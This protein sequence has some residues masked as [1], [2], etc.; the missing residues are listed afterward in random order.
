LIV[1]DAIRIL[2]AVELTLGYLPLSCFGLKKHV[3]E[4]GLLLLSAEGD[5]VH[6]LGPTEAFILVFT[7]DR[8][9]DPASGIV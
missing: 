9:R 6:L 2:N 1:A 4:A 8:R 5:Y 3:L 7:H